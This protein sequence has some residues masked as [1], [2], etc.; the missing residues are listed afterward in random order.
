MEIKENTNYIMKPT[1]TT[2]SGDQWLF[3]RVY[4]KSEPQEG[5]TEGY[6]E[7]RVWCKD[8]ESGEVYTR[9]VYRVGESE[10][11]RNISC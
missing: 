6:Y 10:L 7:I 4:R 5:D 8:K 2:P 3:T 1:S 9:G 11:S